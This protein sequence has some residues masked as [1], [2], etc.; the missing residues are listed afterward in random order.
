MSVM[1]F[2]IVDQRRM[3]SNMSYQ[4]HSGL[5][6]KIIK[7]AA[8]DA[9]F[10]SALLQNTAGTLQKE[11]GL[12]I[13]AGHKITFHESKQEDVHVVLPPV[14]KLSE[15]ELAAVAG[16]RLGAWHCSCGPSIG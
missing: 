3:G 1:A 11:F 2:A 16:G 8:S 10:R 12:Q 15:Q 14:D 7:R 13:P 4:V 6:G 9:A 5:K